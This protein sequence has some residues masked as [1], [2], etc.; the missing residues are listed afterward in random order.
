MASGRG[1]NSGRTPPSRAELQGNIRPRDR[2]GGRRAPIRDGSDGARASWGMRAMPQ[3]FCGHERGRRCGQNGVATRARDRVARIAF[4]LRELGVFTT[5]PRRDHTGSRSR[6][7]C[8]RGR[9][10]AFARA[11]VRDRAE[12]GH[13]ACGLRSIAHVFGRTPCRRDVA[14]RPRFRTRCH[15]FCWAR[16]GSRGSCCC[17]RGARRADH[18]SLPGKLPP[19]TP[20]GLSHGCRAACRRVSG[21][22]DTNVDSGPR[23]HRLIFPSVHLLNRICE[24][25]YWDL[26]AVSGKR[27]LFSFECDDPTREQR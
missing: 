13:G 20:P 4:G 14:S 16:T 7:R 1:L 25:K 23:S 2:N 18:R 24:L 17:R 26:D 10:C 21:F 15:P 12:F 19:A 8:G 6:L 22:C 27:A 5:T 3:F 11:C 9:L